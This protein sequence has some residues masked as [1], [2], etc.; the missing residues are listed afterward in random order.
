MLPK[1]H[2]TSDCRDVRLQV[3]DHTTVAFW[4]IKTFFV[5]LFCVFLPPLLNL[6]CFCWV[7]TVSSF[8]VPILT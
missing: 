2:L 8:I 5:E 1:V 4:I 6:F 3:S 7:L